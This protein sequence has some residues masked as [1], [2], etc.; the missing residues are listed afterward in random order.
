MNNISEQ[1]ILKALSDSDEVFT[2]VKSIVYRT[3]AE[4]EIITSLGFNTSLKVFLA[5]IENNKETET[6]AITI[7]EVV[8]E[9]K[10]E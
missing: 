6:Y 7:D 4:N 3:L 2:A 8:E 9:L 1:K 10:N 5:T